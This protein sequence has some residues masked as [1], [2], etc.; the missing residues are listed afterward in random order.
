[1]SGGVSVGTMFAAGLAAA[2]VATTVLPK[3]MGGDKGAGGTQQVAP[4]VTSPTAMP[5]TTDSTTNAAKR[6]SIAAQLARRG[7]AST[8]LTDTGA[9]DTLG[10]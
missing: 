6:A 7:R 3:L 4:T 9:T 10:G 2:T 8:I 5:S 1:M